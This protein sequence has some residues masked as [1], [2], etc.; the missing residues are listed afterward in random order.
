MRLQV[1]ECVLDI[2]KCVESQ[3]TPNR[4]FL[5]EVEGLIISTYRSV[6]CANA[7]YKKADMD[8]FSINVKVKYVCFN[9]KHILAILGLI[10]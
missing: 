6:K 1:L 5:R 2:S 10:T 8:C 9:M 4:K 7:S 3:I